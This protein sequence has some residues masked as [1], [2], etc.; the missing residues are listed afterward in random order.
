MTAEQV[1]GYL[2]DHPEFFDQYADLLALVTIPD[3]HSGR[4]ISISERQLLSLRDKVRSLETKMSE[5]ISFGVENDS[6]SDKVHALSLALIS[7]QAVPA[8]TRAVYSHLG[9]AFAVP[10]IALRLW[11]VDAGADSSAAEFD[12]VSDAAHAFAAGLTRPSCGLTGTHEALNWFGAAASGLRSIA[13][14]PLRN[15]EGNCFG[16]LVMASEDQNRFYPELGTL[17]IE[18]IGE[19]V[20]TALLRVMR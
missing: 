10:H 17:Y 9:G 1:A 2:Q 4:A 15:A 8:I 19:M 3:P 7:A 16:L 5:L 18:R 13:Q 12:R 20:S 6:I 14:V 11:D